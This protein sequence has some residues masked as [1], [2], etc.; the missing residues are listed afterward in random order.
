MERALNQSLL[1]LALGRHD[2][3]PSVAELSNLIAEAELSILIGNPQIDAS[4][5]ETAWYLHAIASSKY[6]LRVYGLSRQRAAC[7]FAGHLF[8]LAVKSPEIGL[9]DKLKYSFCS[10]VAYLRSEL[11]PN[12]IAAYNQE[13]SSNLPVVSL[14]SDPPLISLCCGAAFL[15]F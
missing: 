7:R 4:L 6:A 15:G 13:I 5:I 1:N 3:L 9:I 14:S 8:E 12:A 11:N 2:N 10:Q